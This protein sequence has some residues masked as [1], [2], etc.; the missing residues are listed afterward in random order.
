MSEDQSPEM[1]TGSLY[2]TTLIIVTT[3]ITLNIVTMVSLP[4]P[5]RFSQGA[6]EYKF[7]GTRDDHGEVLAQSVFTLMMQ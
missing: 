7:G 1:M 2:W 5:S 6:P 3:T 4:I